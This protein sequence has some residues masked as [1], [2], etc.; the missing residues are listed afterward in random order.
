MF[1]RAAATV[2][3][4]GAAGLAQAQS[5][6]QVLD[7]GAQGRRLAGVSATLQRNGERS[8]VRSTDAQGRAVF[9]SALAQDAAA[10]LILSL[11]G[12][13]DTVARCPCDGVSY[14][15]LPAAAAP[16]PGPAGAIA[17]PAAGS[18]APQAMAAANAPAGSA[19]ELNQRGEAAYR[20]GHLEAA[21]ALYQQAIA[22]D[23]GHAPAYGNL[24]LV[25]VK[26]GRDAEAIWASRK[27]IALAKG[28]AGAAIRAGAYYNIG[29]LY[30]ADGRYDEA[31]SNYLAAKRE[32][33]DPGYDRA[34]ERVRGF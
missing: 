7:A 9:D 23:A 30:E 26:L 19:E 8:Q 17:A 12:Y 10:L 5:G 31:M 11:P 15:L 4:L 33:P 6:I 24:G 34:I 20:N 22:A 29:R 27:A 2:L 32:R 13:A 25:C 16:A 28:A 18:G 14:A 21:R 3:L 1:P